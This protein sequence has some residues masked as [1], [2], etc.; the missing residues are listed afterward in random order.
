MLDSER[1]YTTVTN[2]IL[3][4]YNKQL[5]WEIKSMLMGRPAHESAR[6]LIE[7]TGIPLSAD[8]LLEAMSAR[9]KAL[10]PSVEPMPGAI[11]LVQHLKKHGIP[12]AIASG[13][14]QK[15]FELKSLNL[16]ELFSPFEGK[17]V[18]GD[19]PDL[20]RGKPYPDPFFLAARRHLGMKLDPDPDTGIFNRPLPSVSSDELGIRPDEILVFEDGL[21]GVKS[22]QAAGMKVIWVPDPELKN[23]LTRQDNLNGTSP[24][25]QVLN[26]L[27]DWSG[28]QWGLSS[29]DD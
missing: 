27:L 1:L 10:F 18:C 19:D 9:Q 29:L 15:N 14:S 21:A 4:P 16:P 2:E 11:K 23:L 28:S 7:R 22:A 17:V 5:T 26:S 24:P 25:D 20:K 3:A 8:E 13:S 12:I 6:L